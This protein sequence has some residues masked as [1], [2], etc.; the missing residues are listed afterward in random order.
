MCRTWL[1]FRRRGTVV[2]R[3]SV[4]LQDHLYTTPPPHPHASAVEAI[5]PTP[6]LALVTPEPDLPHH[7]QK[8][9]STINGCVVVLI[10]I[11]T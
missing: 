10:C 2:V 4:N 8:R 1:F 11:L 9:K 7:Y 6:M 5:V 3:G